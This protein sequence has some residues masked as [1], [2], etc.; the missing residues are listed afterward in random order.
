[1]RLIYQ[2]A[3]FHLSEECSNANIASPRAIVMTGQFGLYLGWAIILVIAYT[4]KDVTEV[5]AGP[6]GQPMV[7]ALE[8]LYSLIKTDG[9]LTG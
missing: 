2:S 7:C 1:V 3:P 5:V 4:V 8:L 9:S 6:Y